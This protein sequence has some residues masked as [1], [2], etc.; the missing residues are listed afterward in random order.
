[1]ADFEDTQPPTDGQE[2]PVP[3]TG[4]RYPEFLDPG[5][6]LG[7]IVIRAHPKEMTLHALHDVLGAN[8]Y[9]ALLGRIGYAIRSFESGIRANRSVG[10]DSLPDLPKADSFAQIMRSTGRI[11]SVL[12]EEEIDAAA[13]MIT[14]EVIGRGHDGAH[15]VK[16]WGNRHE[17]K[18]FSGNPYS[19]NPYDD[20]FRR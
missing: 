14:K 2:F 15:N 7:Q 4:R 5:E 13:Q 19:G 12:S 1:M 3:P 6:N 16:N 18:K 17:K 11:Y 10:D 9:Q 8:L 20:A